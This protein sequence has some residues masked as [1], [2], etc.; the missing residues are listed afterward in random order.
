MNKKLVLNQNDLEVKYGL[1]RKVLF[2]SSCNMTNQ[3]PNSTNEF[4]HNKSS[5]KKTIPFNEEGRCSACLHKEK[6]HKDIDWKEREEELNA[7]CNKY[8]SKD[9]SY[10]CIVPGS[11]GKDSVYAAWMLKYKYNM[12]PLTVTWSPHLYTEVGWNN[13]QN[14]IHKGGFDNF[15]FT[16]NGKTHRL[17]TRLATINM[18][19]PFQPFIMG[20]KTYVKKMCA[21]FNIPLAFYGEM[22]GEYGNITKS[23]TA[24]ERTFNDAGHGFE[25]NETD[26]EKLFFGGV[27]GE[28]LIKKYKVEKNDLLAYTPLSS[29]IEEKKKIDVHY[30]GYYLKWDPQECYYFSVDKIDFKANPVR[31]EGTY[32]KYNSLDDKIDG[33]FYYTSYIKFGMGRAMQDSAQ[34]CRNQKITPEEGRA[35]IKKFDGELPQRYFN[36]FLEYI[37]MNTEEFHDLCDTFRSPHLWKKESS[38]WKLRHTVNKD[39]VDDKFNT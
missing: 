31:T 8:R 30:L 19:H 24:G 13:F 38:G 17:L 34:E 12:H 25:K 9:G 27:S 33:Y 14:W 15:L 32:S 23:K 5:Q 11:G 28:E 1:P 35:L 26:P 21:Q 36:E 37:S 10:D 3:R 16:P 29:E 18:L 20:Q 6:Q 39:G 22:P 2:C 4:L 7:L